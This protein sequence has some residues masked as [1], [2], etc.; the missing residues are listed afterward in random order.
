MKKL[1]QII[2]FTILCFFIQINIK[3]QNIWE[4]IQ[5]KVNIQFGDI[6]E[7]YDI[8]NVDENKNKYFNQRLEF[9]DPYN[10]LQNCY[11]FLASSNN[12]S[13]F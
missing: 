2:L 11:L 10:A 13:W 5:Q 12:P 3:P 1:N 6:Y 8:Q 7:V 4:E 9:T